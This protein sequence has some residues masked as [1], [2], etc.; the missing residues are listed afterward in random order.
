MIIAIKSVIELKKKTLNK[1]LARIHSIFYNFMRQ[2]Q[3][4]DYSLHM[5]NTY[6][7]SFQQRQKGG[8]GEYGFDSF[9][10]LITKLKRC[11]II[12]LQYTLLALKS[13]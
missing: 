4:N 3:R 13:T 9:N 5:Y 10:S 11:E 6:W 12:L 8:K 2:T 1:I 7:K